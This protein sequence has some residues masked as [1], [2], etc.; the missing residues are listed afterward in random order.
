VSLWRWI[1]H[2]SYDDEALWVGIECV[3]QRS[4]S[5][6]PL[7]RRDRM[8]GEL[9]SA[10]DASQ[11]GLQRLDRRHPGV[12]SI[13]IANGPIATSGAVNTLPAIATRYAR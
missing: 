10:D 3:Q 7:T 11:R 4:P 9:R 1:L 8:F 6:R 2:R 5:A 12:M 13:G